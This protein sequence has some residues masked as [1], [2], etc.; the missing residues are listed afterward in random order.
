MQINFKT[1]VIGSLIAVG[2]TVLLFENY[3]PTQQAIGGANDWWDTS[4]IYKMPI[5]I[6]NTQANSATATE[7]Q[8]LVEISSTTVSFWSH[9]MSNGSDIRFIDANNTTR[10]N[11][12]TQYFNYTSQIAQIWVQVN[13]IPKNATTAI[14]LYYGNS[15]ANDLSNATTT[16]SYSTTTPLYYV[17]NNSLTSA[18]IIVTSLVPNNI[19]RYNTGATSSLGYMATTS[20]S[21][22]TATSVISATGP[23]FAKIIGATSSDAL[24]PIS[25]AGTQFLYPQVTGTTETTYRYSPYT[26]ASTTVYNGTTAQV[27]SIL[28]ATGTASSSLLNFT[29]SGMLESTAPVLAFFHV[30]GT[31]Y[32]IPGIPSTKRDLYGIKSALTVGF[33]YV[34]HG[35]N[36]TTYSVFC[37]NG[38][39]ANVAAQNRGARYSITACTSANQGAGNAIRITNIT[40]P[41]GAI[42]YND[43]D[44]TEVSAFLP[45]TE[46]SSEYVIPTNSQYVAI[47]CPPKAGS[48]VISLYSPAN[49]FISSTSC[50]VS[51]EYP[52]KAYFGSTT[53]G[54]FIQSGSRVS[55][56]KPFY[57][58]FEDY[59]TP[60]GTTGTESSLF[61]AV[62]SRKGLWSYPTL[63]LGAEQATGTVASL[64]IANI[65]F[66]D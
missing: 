58:Y 31:G 60:A 1:I 14:N 15:S 17:V 7:Q 50:T 4:F 34:G 46:L 43:S 10:L 39:S 13:T 16:F 38:T 19:I 57:A 44:G 30:P 21:S 66:F 8:I 54:V 53:N 56:T 27:P 28:V 65:I 62:S 51:G 25:Q 63:T 12:W 52:G 61:G 35:T 45:D 22:P 32:S 55:G 23:I 11:H 49:A 9:V 26:S 5:T 29:S 6:D 37:S 59:T 2:L 48:N 24:V 40:Q 41:I 18:S 36:V 33:N 47:A 20:F 42:Q 64:I 3:Q